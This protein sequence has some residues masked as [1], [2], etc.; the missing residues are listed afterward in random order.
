MEKT[1]PLTQWHSD[2]QGQ[3]VPFGGFLM[4]VQ[5]AHGI[6][7]EHHCVRQKAG[8]FDVSHMGELRLK[9]KDAL[10]NLHYL[11]SNDFTDLEIGRIRYGILIQKDGCAVD[12]LLVYKMAED[13]YFIC[14]NASNIE[15]DEA[16]FRA[17]LFGSVQFENVSNHYGQIALQGPHSVEILQQLTDKIPEH[18]YSFIDHVSIESMDVLVSRTGYTGE[19]GFELYVQT[20]DTVKLWERLLEVG[21]VYGLEPCGL[22]ARDTLRLEAAMPLYG[23]E[24]SEHIT[25]L[26][27]GLKMFTKPLTAGLIAKDILQCEPQRRRIGLSLIDRGIAREGAPVLFQGKVV[28]QVTSGTHSPSLNKS[29][30]M[31]L[32]DRSV[33]NET[34]FRIEVRGRILAA[35]KT[36]LPFYTRSN[37]EQK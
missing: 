25:P 4:P 16:Y 21:E 22:G 24:L 37:K 31:A 19:D 33:F 7:H 14:V 12:D 29:I 20:Q 2:H 35:E 27:A 26:E 11:I 3:M 6:L 30:A 36:K 18:Y 8:L 1:T 5:Y 10:A 15:K 34:Q 28:G 23:H 9:G 17:H 32:V 13:D